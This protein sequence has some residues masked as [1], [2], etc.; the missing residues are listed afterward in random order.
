MKTPKF[1]MLVS[2]DPLTQGAN[3]HAQCGVVV[4]DAIFA[5]TIDETVTGGPNQVQQFLSGLQGL[6]RKCLKVPLQGNGYIYAA[7]EATYG[8][9]ISEADT[10]F[11]EAT[12]D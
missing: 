4:K 6:C 11:H 9:E 8:L 10:E 7:R 1:H 2:G 12:K 5:A 3:H